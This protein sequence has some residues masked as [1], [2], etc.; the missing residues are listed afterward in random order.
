MLVQ[1]MGGLMAI[2]GEADGGPVLCNVPVVDT[3]GALAAGQ[4]IVTALLHRERTGE[5]QRLDVSLLNCL[6]LAHAAR[7]PVFWATGEEPARL[8]SAHPILAPFQAFTAKD[9]WIYVAVLT[10][11]LWEPFCAALDRPEL[12]RDP[13]FAS[14]DDRA[15]H[16]GALTDV[17]APVF[18]E[19]TV[20]DWMGA[21]ETRGVLC[22][23]VNR[24]AD[25]EG[26]P[27]IQA[28]E[29]IVEEAHPRAGRFRTVDTAVRFART[30]GSRRAGAP[31]LGEHTDEVLRAAGHSEDELKRLRAAG[32]IR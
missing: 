17:L 2:T 10:D 11:S 18:R 27:Q 5:G 28:S 24:Y 8:G 4:G 31:S 30:P 16:R 14:R 7:L 1:A 26:D 15:R 21:L 22:A 32:V 25:L 19:R 6:M 23:P 12:A 3:M 29:I 9:G 13:R 20:A